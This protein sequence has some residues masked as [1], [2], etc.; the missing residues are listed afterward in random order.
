MGNGPSGSKDHDFDADGAGT[1]RI[2]WHFMYFVGR[3]FEFFRLI[4][5]KMQFYGIMSH[6][7]AL[8]GHSFCRSLF[9]FASF[10]TLG[11]NKPTCHKMI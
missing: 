6:A 3:F 4:P 5:L 1:Y 8:Q 2:T 11:R 10:A 7:D 9:F